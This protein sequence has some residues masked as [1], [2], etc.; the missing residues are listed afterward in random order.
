MR[1]IVLGT[2]ALLA[3]GNAGQTSAAGASTVF[4]RLMV[5]QTAISEIDAIDPSIAKTSFDNATSLVGS[6]PV[7]TGWLSPRVSIYRSYIGFQNALATHSVPLGVQTVAYD[8]EAWTYTPLSE[9]QNPGVTEKA[10]C[11]LAHASGYR[12][13][14]SPALTLI[15]V[16]SWY[17]P[18][19]HPWQE[20]VAHGMA[21]D[22]A[23]YADVFDVQAQWNEAMSD[24]ASVVS[25]VAGSARAAN[26]S[27]GVLAGLSTGPSGQTVAGA[28]LYAAADA[29]EGIVDGYW[30]NVPS[31]NAG[32]PECTTAQPQVAVDFLTLLQ[33]D[34]W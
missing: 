13:M 6:G 24:F 5:T 15:S 27:V 4:P 33:Q 22:A 17:S 10:F 20:F 11:R 1:A 2:A 29:T 16:Q 26:P 12:C 28:Q 19:S 8:N 3:I 31:A 7:A 21:A 25:L 34:G 18:S 32:C 30:L 14:T 9:Q 23:R